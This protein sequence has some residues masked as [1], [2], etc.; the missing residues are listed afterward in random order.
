[1]GEFIDNLMMTFY[2]GR[3]AIKILELQLVLLR[4]LLV[5]Y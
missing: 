3:F 2:N 5:T 4:K 1:M